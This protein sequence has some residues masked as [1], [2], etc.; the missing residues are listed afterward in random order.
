MLLFGIRDVLVVLVFFIPF[1]GGRGV[2]VVVV[3]VTEGMSGT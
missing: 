3:V 1:V 2:L